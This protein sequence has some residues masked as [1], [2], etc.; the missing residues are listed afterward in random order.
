MR[1][2]SADRYYRWCTYIFVPLQYAGLFFGFWCLAFADMTR[3]ER[4]GLSITVGMSAAIGINAAHELGHK[5]EKL[6]QGLAKI[7]LAQS[8]YGHFY[9]E[10]N[11]GH[12]VKVATLQIRRARDLASLCSRS[13]PARC[14]EDSSRVSSSKPLVYI[15]RATHSGT[16]ATQFSSPGR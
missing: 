11:V 1:T 9:V 15:V 14:T 7:A 4:V 12:H 3:G 8:V 10:H 2:L 13:I 6:E 16:G 5:R